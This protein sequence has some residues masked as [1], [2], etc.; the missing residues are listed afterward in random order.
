MKFIPVGAFIAFCTKALIIS[1]SLPEVLAI[2]FSA[3]LAGYFYFVD[4]NKKFN[5]R[6]HA[7]NIKLET[8]EKLVLDQKVLTD[9]LQ[10]GVNQ[11]KAAYNFRKQ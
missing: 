8:L 3:L 4:E 5:N 1:P 10:S 6:V 11:L 7:Q 2:A 9:G